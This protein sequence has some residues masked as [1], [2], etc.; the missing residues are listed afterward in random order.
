MDL[1]A[2]VGETIDDIPCSNDAILI[3]LMT[4]VNIACGGHGG[5][6]ESI[7]SALAL[8]KHNN[9]TVGAH[10]SYPDRLNFGR[11]T[12]DLKQNE[13]RE[14]ITDQLHYLKKLCD[15]LE[16]KISYVKAHGALYNDMFNESEIADWFLEAIENFDPN[17][18]ILGQPRGA[19]AK[20][21]NDRG[22]RYFQ[23]GFS[24]RRYQIDGSLK[25]RSHENAVLE[26]PLEIA[27]QGYLIASKRQ[28]ISDSG[29]QIS[30][31]VDSICI[32]GDNP[33]SI[34]AARNLRDRLREAKI[35]IES[36]C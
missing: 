3:P 31:E 1:N 16:V 6:L 27:A 14:T 33:A 8:A 10:P 15:Q 21:A 26:K 7:S 35:P 32:H 36:F 23:E 28:V 19:L 2:D 20:R 22:V 30:L 13:L 29:D 18:A 11:R 24:D 17:L 9:V 5:N 12:I 4:S 34:D 25:P